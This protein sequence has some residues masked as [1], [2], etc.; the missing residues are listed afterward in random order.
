M[1]DSDVSSDDMFEDTSVHLTMGLDTHVW[2]LTFAHL[3]WS[4]LQRNEL[5]FNL[6]IENDKTYWDVVE[7]IPVGFL[8]KNDSWHS[9]LEAIREGRSTV[10]TEARQSIIDRTKELLV[11]L[12]PDRWRQQQEGGGDDNVTGE[13]LPNNDSIG[14]VVD[15]YIMSHLKELMEIQEEMFS[16]IKMYEESSL[17]KAFQ[18]SQ[19]QNAVM[20]KFGGFSKNKGVEE[21]FGQMR[22]AREKKVFGSSGGPS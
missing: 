14:E 5:E 22:S 1:V 16:G 4:L 12:E 15:Y 3:R 7:S 18:C 6:E 2:A 19:R 11:Q 21:S 8:R 10:P 20:E 9:C 17:I 13:E